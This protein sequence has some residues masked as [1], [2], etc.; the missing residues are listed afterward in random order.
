MEYYEINLKVFQYFLRGVLKVRKYNYLTTI[1]FTLL[2]LITSCNSS[3]SNIKRNMTTGT[4]NKLVFNRKIKN[5]MEDSIILERFKD[6]KG[7]LTRLRDEN[8]NTSKY[9]C[10]YIKNG[11]VFER[12]ITINHMYDYSQYYKL[13]LF[14][15]FKQEDYY[16]DIDTQKTKEFL[17]KMSAHGAIDIPIKID[18]LSEGLHD[19]IFVLVRY[20]DVKSL[21]DNYRGSTY[22]THLIFIRFSLI[23]GNSSISPLKMTIPDENP[24]QNIFS[25]IFINKQ[26]DRR[27]AW[28]SETVYSGTKIPY[29]IHIGTKDAKQK[30]KYALM[31][32]GNWEQIPFDAEGNKVYFF[33]LDKDKVATFPALFEVPQIEGIYDLT[34][35]LIH[36]P[37]EILD[38]QKNVVET[39]I[40]VGLD[41]K[42]QNQ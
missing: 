32:L 9:C 38:D 17:F 5:E 37:F 28:L 1:I 34:P 41:I 23:V 15:N 7:V 39:A 2:F 16:I 18:P 3:S 35:V 33:E 27:K 24:L 42:K 31:V 36:N 20:P 6:K 11:E 40:R 12:F 4:D 25:G 21:D 26:M 8:G 14:I 10:H 30:Q 29:Y 19:V 22:K 13:I